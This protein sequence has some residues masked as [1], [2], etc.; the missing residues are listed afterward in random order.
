MIKDQGYRLIDALRDYLVTKGY[1][2]DSI[3]VYPRVEV[4]LSAGGQ[5][6]DKGAN[7]KPVDVV[8][9]VITNNV[10]EGEAL[11]MSEALQDMLISDPVEVTSFSIDI[12]TMTGTTP[13]TEESASDERTIN[14][15][16]VN[17]TYNLTQTIF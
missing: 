16:L 5:Q 9:D 3:N 10:N 2:N 7:S 15:I 8:F 11:A 13:L 12:V 17:Y 4:Y 1:V 6:I 14:R